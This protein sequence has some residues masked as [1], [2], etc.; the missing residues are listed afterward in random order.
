MENQ[1]YSTLSPV[2][3]GHPVCEFTQSTILRPFVDGMDWAQRAAFIS[4]YEAKLDAAYPR[5]PDGSILFSFKRTFLMIQK[6]APR[7][8]KRAP[9]GHV[10]PKETRYAGT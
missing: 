1:L 8:E 2:G 4:Q 9:M 10:R 7:V 3:I 5:K 6:A